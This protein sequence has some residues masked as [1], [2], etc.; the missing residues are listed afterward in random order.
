MSCPKNYSTFDKYNIM[1]P[2]YI[3]LPSPQISYVPTFGL[4][5]NYEL[6]HGT[7]PTGNNYFQVCAAYRNTCGPGNSKCRPEIPG[8]LTPIQ[9]TFDKANCWNK[10]AGYVCKDE[11]SD[12]G[13]SCGDT[14]GPSCQ[15]APNCQD[16]DK[17]TCGSTDPYVCYHKDKE[18]PSNN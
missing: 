17:K 10:S 2:G 3:Q 11:S 12:L 9:P 6:Y 8:G 15:P 14:P 18:C 5:G 4:S 7:C 13:Y 16:Q 1:S